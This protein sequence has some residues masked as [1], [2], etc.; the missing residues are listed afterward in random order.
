MTWSPT[1]A[2]TLPACSGVS[3]AL[4]RWAPPSATSSGGVTAFSLHATRLAKHASATR[5]TVTRTEAARQTDGNTAAK[6]FTTHCALGHAQVHP[7]D[8]NA[9]PRRARR[10]HDR[11]PAAPPRSSLQAHRPQAERRSFVRH[12]RRLRDH[13]RRL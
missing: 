10:T 9:S 8:E 3:D 6:G 2:S 12:H 4:V 7:W 11:P 1:R 13:A 5:R